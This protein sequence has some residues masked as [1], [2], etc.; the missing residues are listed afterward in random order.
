MIEVE[1]NV[2]INAN[3]GVRISGDS[4]EPQFSDGQIVWVHQQQ[5]IEDGEIGIFIYNGD[6]YCK[7]YKSDSNGVYLISLNPQY[8]PIQVLE[9]DE[10]RVFGKVV[11]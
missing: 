10:L 4:M 3:F 2:P 5:I 9:T 8:S 11:R 1:E 7:K 6:A